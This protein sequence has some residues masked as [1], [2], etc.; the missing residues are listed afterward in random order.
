ML[1]VVSWYVAVGGF[2]TSQST[3]V[4][5]VALETKVEHVEKIVGAKVNSTL[6]AQIDTLKDI[7]HN[8]T[9]KP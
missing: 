2:K 4:E 5:L 3:M 6:E 1:G 7:V 8:E 9:E